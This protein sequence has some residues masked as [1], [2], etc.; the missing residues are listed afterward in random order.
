MNTQLN[1]LFEIAGKPS[2]LIIGL[3]SGT[4]IDG[5][6]VALCRFSGTGMDTR[7]ELLEFETVPYGSDYKEEIASIFSKK[8]VDLQKLCLLNGWI[9]RQHAAIILQCL[10][11]WKRPAVTIDLIA[12]HG[13]TIFHAP[14]SL[15]GIEKFS[16]ATLQL[17]DG[18]HMAVETGIITLSDFRQKHV[19]S[20]GEGAPLAAYGDFL[21][22]SKRD[23]NRIMLNIGGIANFTYLPGNL[24]ADEVF[25]SDTGTGNTLMDALT[26]K[27]FPGSYFDEGAAIAGRGVIHAGLLAA[28]KDHPF[29]HQ[30]FP[31]TTGPELFNLAYL[32]AAMQRCGATELTVEDTMATLNRFSAETIAEAIQTVIKDKSGFRFFA[33]GG[34]M[35]NPLLMQHLR[36]LLPG[37][38]FESTASLGINPDAKEAVL[39]AV[40]AN[41]SIYG[42]S[43]HFG[44]GRNGIPNVSMGKISFPG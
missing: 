19:A 31:K 22:F 37:C 4:S 29:F 3:M 18:D 44:K 6:D 38:P 10:E 8:M 11:K 13:Q 33:S 39:F 24:N 42:G 16:N 25:C 36:D 7:I 32:E 21:I 1:H 12:S 23:E 9:A 26:R 34:G 40:L 28:L 30:P 41:E 35:H 15:H 17:G 5:L 43:I 20:G 27:H 14:K 2:R